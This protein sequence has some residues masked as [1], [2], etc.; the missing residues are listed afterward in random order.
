LREESNVRADEAQVNKIERI[1]G[2]ADGPHCNKD[3]ALIWK[4]KGKGEEAAFNGLGMGH[5]PPCETIP[6]GLCVCL[7]PP[8]TFHI[9]SGSDPYN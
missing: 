7:Q 5:T 9:Q 3:R 8:L 6:F 1:E 2:N 4:A